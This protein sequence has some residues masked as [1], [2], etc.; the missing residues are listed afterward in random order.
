MT[1]NQLFAVAPQ[2]LIRTKPVSAKD[3]CEAVVRVS[4]GGVRIFSCQHTAGFFV[5]QKSEEFKGGPESLREV[6]GTVFKDYKKQ[7]ARRVLCT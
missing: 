1:Q 6:N 2:S 3:N 7:F 4:V 5:G